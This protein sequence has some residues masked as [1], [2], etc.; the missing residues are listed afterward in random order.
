MALLPDKVVAQVGNQTITFEAKDEALSSAINRLYK[1]SGVN[2]GSPVAEVSRYPKINL[3]K[4]K[5]TVFETLK[6]LLK[7]TDL[8]CKRV[9]DMLVV[10]KKSKE[11]QSPPPAKL[12]NV[13]GKV[14]DEAGQPLPAITILLQGTDR[15]TTTNSSGSFD[16]DQVPE[17]APIIAQ[18]IGFPAQAFNATTVMVLRLNRSVSHLDEVQVIAYGTTTR[19]FNTGSV[20]T[21]TASEIAKQ[22]VTNPLAALAG[23]IPGVV[24]TQSSGQIGSSFNIQIRGRN[25]ISQ[26]SD[27]LFIVDGVPYAANNNGISQIGGPFTYNLAPGKSGD[28]SPFNS[29]NPS[30]IES[31]D[32]LKDADATAIYGSRGANGVVLITT[33]KGKAGSTKVDVNIQTGVNKVSRIVQLM[34]TQQYVQMRK[35]AFKNDGTTMTNANAYDILLWDT[36]RYTDWGKYLLGGTANTS[37]VRTSASGGNRLTQFLVGGNYHQETTVF[38]GD[39]QY[40]RG[41]MHLNLSHRNANEKFLVT[42]T[43]N[44][45]ADENNNSANNLSNYVLTLL[46]NLPSLYD[47]LGRL[48]W[49]G[50]GGYTF[51]NP[52]SYLKTYYRAKTNTLIANLQLS[53]QIQKN[54]RLLFNS[55]YNN[56]DID[57]VR[58]SPIS[59][60][61]PANNPTGSGI[62]GNGSFSSVILEP[63]INY[64]SKLFSGKLDVLLGGTWQQNTNTS[65]TINAS[66]YTSDALLKSPS[67][68]TT[69]SS[70]GSETQYKYAAVF[71]RV[72]Y[73]YANTYLLN[74][75]WRRDGSSRFGPG[76]QWA[77]FGA[78]G[79]GWIFSN[80]PVFS[81]DH[82]FLSFGKLRTSYGV[83]G[84]DA[85][86][87]YQYLDT[88]SNSQY[89]YSGIPGLYPTRLFNADYG[90]ETNRKAEVSIDIGF[91]K[92]RVLL[93]TAWYRNRSDN[94]L[95]ANTLA[96][97]TGFTSII[98]NLPALVQNTGWEF[99]LNSVNINS[100]YFKWTS[101]LNLSI[102]KNKLLSFPGLE[103]STYRNTYAIGKSLNIGSGYI[104][105]GIN[106]QTGLYNFVDSV[107][108][109]STTASYRVIGLVNL[110]PQ[111][112]GGLSNELTYKGWTFSFFFDFR[113]Q[114]G[115]SHLYGQRVMPGQRVNQF[116][117]FVNVWH[118]PGDIAEYMKYTNSTTSEVYKTNS[119]MASDGAD[120]RYAD[121]S[122]IRL[123]NVHLSYAFNP[124]LLKKIKLSR[125]NIFVQG[126]NL[127][128]ASNYIGND[129]EI[130]ILSIMPPLRSFM[131]GINLSL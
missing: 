2:I 106:P 51:T 57:E 37:D 44:Y 105:A 84:N 22:P 62:F 94:Q 83:T 35:E 40:K 20:G 126:Q 110:D 36:T 81:A 32:V 96:A 25:S 58:A 117:E 80:L 38:P 121:A 49:V 75:T 82:S 3:P 46:P 11:E 86:G 127:W 131:A 60:L 56:L 14:V 5:R 27:P 123:R 69:V 101:S 114:M 41:G 30:D 33:K 70:L 100:Q 95:V 91:F 65:T 31:I 103:S 71:G 109:I 89:P 64:N 128:L 87:D 104:T 107:G 39:M 28:L 72:N 42:L 50:E 76:R 118:K 52:L 43:A 115:Y 102:P 63:Q 12:I 8:D 13:S 21:V 124:D 97:Q 66:G 26:G 130:Q 111:Y 17:D 45:S 61:N 10:F 23:R 125:L 53:Y 59:S 29:L 48:N 7:G 1:A 34:N 116:E 55:G 73:N 120:V 68:A 119:I 78:A 113:K 47:S 6:A 98:Q 74:L 108:G 112:Y 79:L 122:F 67:G 54:L 9:A 24:V 88:Y 16:L 77:N 93:S 19:R 129:P 85:I 99:G 4:G 18:G 92:D 15:G 90:W